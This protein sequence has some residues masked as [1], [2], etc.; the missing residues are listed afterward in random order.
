MLHYLT[1]TGGEIGQRIKM[2]LNTNYIVRSTNHNHTKITQ[3]LHSFQIYKMHYSNLPKIDFNVLVDY[4]IMWSLPSSRRKESWAF[5]YIYR[6]FCYCDWFNYRDVRWFV[7]L[8]LF[9]FVCVFTFFF[10]TIFEKW[11]TYIFEKFKR[12]CWCVLWF[13]NMTDF[14][15]KNF[16][17]F[18]YVIVLFLW[19][20]KAS[21]IQ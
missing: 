20:K 21:L 14:N 6:L 2:I 19:F 12:Y 15:K 13:K 9:F 16:I 1:T 11:K 17:S 5:T 8:L 7:I 4:D 10:L 3:S 18:C